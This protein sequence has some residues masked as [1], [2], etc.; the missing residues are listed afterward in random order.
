MAQ[1]S[2]LFKLMDKDDKTYS[3]DE[4]EDRLYR[5]IACLWADLEK[6]LKVLEEKLLFDE[7]L[8]SLKNTK[9]WNHKRRDYILCTSIFA[10]LDYSSYCWTIFFIKCFRRF[11]VKSNEYWK[12]Y[13]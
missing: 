1:I 10:S 4:D 2:L 11:C 9:E 8:E 7:A 5:D 12:L 3:E 6:L 13:K